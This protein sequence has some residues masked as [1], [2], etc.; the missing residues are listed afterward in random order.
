MLFFDPQGLTSEKNL[1]NLEDRKGVLHFLQKALLFLQ[2]MTF[3]HNYDR[4]WRVV[5]GD[6][7]EKS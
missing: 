2:N 3:A 1:C 5:L 6:P 7:R 4:K